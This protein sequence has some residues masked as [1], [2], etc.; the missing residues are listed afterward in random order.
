MSCVKHIKKCR[1]QNHK[2]TAILCLFILHTAGCT[3]I[4]RV[5]F[6]RSVCLS[7]ITRCNLW[8]A[9]LCNVVLNVIKNCEPTAAR[10]MSCLVLSILFKHS[11][12]IVILFRKH[13]REISDE[14]VHSQFPRPDRA[15]TEW[16]ILGLDNAAH[17]QRCTSCNITVLSNC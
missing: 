6:L 2:K 5:L 12:V 17:A 7:V 8:L 4:A 11:S 16:Q 10:L 3:S 14:I 15:I 13:C 1:F 9:S